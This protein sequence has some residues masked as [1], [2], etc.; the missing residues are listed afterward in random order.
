MRRISDTTFDLL[1]LILVGLRDVPPN[2]EWAALIERLCHQ[3]G[4]RL[5]ARFLRL[6]HGGSRR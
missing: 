3:A 6:K 4:A 1:V 5:F 2:T